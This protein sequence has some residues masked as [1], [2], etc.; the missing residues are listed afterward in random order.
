MHAA[1]GDYGATEGPMWE[2]GKDG[3]GGDLDNGGSGG[4]VIL[5]FFSPM[6]IP[7]ATPRTHV[8]PRHSVAD[9]FPT[10]VEVQASIREVQVLCPPLHP[11]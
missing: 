3:G 6:H 7:H 5:P 4:S 9:H 11:P 1:E 2:S 8:H 10:Q